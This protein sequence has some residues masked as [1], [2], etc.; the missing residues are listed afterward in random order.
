MR[1]ELALLPSNRDVQALRRAADDLQT[2]VATAPLDATSWTLLSQVDDRLGQPLRSLRAQAESRYA[3]GDL[4]GAIDRL[5]AGRLAGRANGTP[6]FIEA[7]VIEARLR[8]IETQRKQ[9]AAEMRGGRGGSEDT[10]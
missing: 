10:Q 4:S 1:S 6:D 8:D 5:R 2:R 3:L 7:S 9:L